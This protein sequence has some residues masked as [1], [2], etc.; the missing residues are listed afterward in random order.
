MINWRKGEIWDRDVLS[1]QIVE[2][3]LHNFRSYKDI[4]L[5][6]DPNLNIIIGTNNAGKSNLVNALVKFKEIILGNNLPLKQIQTILP[7]EDW[8]LKDESSGLKIDL[9]IQL[10]TSEITV[11]NQLI[12]EEEGKY[13]DFGQPIPEPEDNQENPFD[14]VPP[15]DE[16]EE[17]NFVAERIRVEL[18][19]DNQKNGKFKLSFSIPPNFFKEY[20]RME[21]HYYQNVFLKTT[22][23]YFKK[24]FFLY[25]T[26]TP[27]IEEIVLFPFLQE[28]WK[29]NLKLLADIRKWPD[30]SP[31]NLANR[32]TK[33]GAVLPDV[34][35]NLK[36]G[37]EGD[38]KK[39]REI[40]KNFALIYSDYII[41]VVQIPP[42][43]NATIK[44]YD[45]L[46]QKEFTLEQMGVG[47]FEILF[48]LT[49]II[50]SKDRVFLLEEPE[51]H[52]YPAIQKVIVNFFQ[53]QCQENQVFI[54]THSPFFIDSLHENYSIHLIHRDESGSSGI[55]L[56]RQTYGSVFDALGVLPSDFLL[57]DGILLVEG[58]DDIKF[59]REILA[60]SI[61]L[62]H[63]QLVH[64]H[65]KNTPILEAD[66]NL[67][68]PLIDRQFRV[69]CILDRDEGN[70]KKIESLPEDMRKIIRRLPVR[71]MENFYLDPEVLVQYLSTQ[72]A[73]YYSVESAK[74]KI[75]EVL[76]SAFSDDVKWVSSVKQFFDQYY[77]FITKKEREPF[78]QMCDLNVWLEKLNVFLKGR[79]H[80]VNMDIEFLKQQFSQIRTDIAS[81]Y[82][83]EGWKVCPGKEIRKKVV[84][85]FEE[86]GTP[87]DFNQ[88]RTIL[89]T[90]STTLR[91]LLKIID[92]YFEK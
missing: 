41:D 83:S 8:Y 71:E 84:K 53:S 77:R 5:Q 32:E 27:Y 14:G 56:S 15:Q 37:N 44:I 51:L 20:K 46:Y 9:K 69:L 39:F 35:F 55:T 81:K 63:I 68:K 73:S 52:L 18:K 91:E 74:A 2:L 26:N 42:Q 45:N 62:N 72:Y 21:T 11:L 13:V 7:L 87:L 79:L 4:K 30:T 29:N 19:I 54:I 17:A 60:D 70:T 66:Y 16:I 58:P 67:L 25:I 34:L 64:Y 86:F 59:F 57:Y 50:T 3:E 38:R 12:K 10:S 23:E 22:E 28:L 31:I 33:D 92:E 78:L 65:G 61:N 49:N 1:M 47:V 24:L 75:N 48:F 43:L 80:S 89:R 36:N 76:T 82:Q 85:T 90:K 88:I 6:L 40:Q